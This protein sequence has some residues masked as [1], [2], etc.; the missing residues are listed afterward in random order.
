MLNL[1]HYSRCLRRLY[2]TLHSE[3]VNLVE[4]G[5]K[6]KSKVLKGAPSIKKQ[7]EAKNIY[8]LSMFPYPSGSLHIGHLR[9]YSITD[10]LNRFYQ[11]NGYQVL[12][13]MGWDAFGLPAENA[14]I[15]RQIGPAA[16]TEQ[17]ITKMKQ[18]MDTMLANFDWDREVTTSHPDYY[19]F[20][21]QIF[22][23]L[24]KN[25]LAY[26]K[27]AEINWDPVDQTVLA[28]EQVDS[29]GKSWRSGAIV[30]KRK[31]KQWFLG[32]TKFAHKLQK[33]LEL[34][35][36]WPQKVKT[37][38]KNWIG[39]SYGTE[40]V[41]PIF[42]NDKDQ[43][44]TFTTRVE[45]LFSVQYI[46]LATTHPL[47]EE[48]A[49]SD[50]DLKNFLE[51]AK[52]LPEDSKQ[53]FLLKNTN[54]LHPITS[55]LNIPIFVA[56]YVLSGYGHGAVMGCPAH[57]ERDFAFWKQNMPESE[58]NATIFP[59]K[60]SSEAQLSLPYCEKSGMLHCPGTEFDGMDANIASKAV[61]KALEELGRG[62]A[63]VNYKLRDWLISRQRFWGAPIPIV[64]CDHC[65][66]VPVPSEDL[67]VR[68]PAVDNLAARGNPLKNLD[69]FVNTTC[70]SCGS[71]AKRETD[72]MDTFMDSSWYFFRYTDPKNT[73]EPFGSEIASKYLPVDLYIGGVEHAILHLLY[74][75]FISKFLAAI[76]N[77]DD[78]QG[79][80]EPFKRLVTQ[81][82]V[83]GR[84]LVDPASGRFLKP[85]EVI[86]TDTD[87]LI[88]KATGQQPS[89]VYEKMSKSKHNG[90]D[91]DDCIAVHGADATRAHILFQA[92][93]GDVLNW[94]EAKIVGVERW[95]R[96]VIKLA[97]SLSS[98][99]S[100]ETS[101]IETPAPSD[102]DLEFHN[103]VQK[104]LQSITSSFTHS[105]SL[106]T[107]ISD[108][109][110]LANLIENA[111][112]AKAVSH[113]L[114]TKSFRIL[115]TSMYPVTPTVAEEAHEIICRNKE[116]AW[117]LYSWPTA[118]NVR[119]SELVDYRVVINGKMRFTHNADKS[120]IEDQ[121]YAIRTLLALPSSQKYFAEKTIKKVIVRN[122]VFSFVVT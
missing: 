39:E 23:E 122:K 6:W 10:A 110:K 103:E 35:N 119:E 58:V 61:T 91:P 67:P 24:Y 68:L 90:A 93:I 111:H 5:N 86:T 25:G 36:E 107:V 28:N 70:P 87:G 116:L 31:L 113:D 98:E 13:P 69:S 79:S 105:L 44:T 85:D 120:F 9:V 53:G 108:Y 40:V 48:L 89:I 20:T 80:G 88:I 64:H 50:P 102:K 83:H 57:D 94:D 33:D 73:E 99:R 19:K 66:T 47:V 104:L 76:G 81:G 18:Q 52:S 63:A 45:T 115:V 17:N 34:L 55:Q 21:Q 82:M 97:R 32:I 118:E 96:K 3:D 11:L 29:Q 1:R 95:L 117:N 2:G 92:P 26:Q 62:K 71:P 106:N 84:T 114:L 100:L 37:M 109:M 12:Y 16:W 75:R 49:S 72:T 43:I 30:E 54:A 8:I 41:F 121:D 27:D 112:R 7:D 4:I 42:Q 78:K 14:A 65:G 101:T 74:S 60:A 15:D 46:A 56:P 22:L 59:E 38:Q 77:W 51:L